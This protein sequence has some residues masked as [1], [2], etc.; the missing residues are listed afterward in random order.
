MNEKLEILQ[1]LVEN[2]AFARSASA[3]AKAL[4]GKGKM[5][6][7][8]LMEGKTKDSTVDEV[9]DKILE[10]YHLSDVTLLKFRK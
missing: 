7:Y 2:R 8:R 1:C 5:V 3:F 9:W 10:R 4:G 6:I